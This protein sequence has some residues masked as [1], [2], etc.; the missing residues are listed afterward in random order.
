MVMSNG[1]EYWR[2]EA[3]KKAQMQASI[4]KRVLARDR[5]ERRS[6]TSRRREK[7]SKVCGSVILDDMRTKKM[8]LTVGLASTYTVAQICAAPPPSIVHAESVCNRSTK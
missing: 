3:A 2:K 6:Q 1:D 8:F 4:E 7:A 5:S